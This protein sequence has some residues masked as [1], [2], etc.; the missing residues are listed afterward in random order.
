MIFS[1]CNPEYTIGLREN[2]CKKKYNST[3]YSFDEQRHVALVEDMVSLSLFDVP[4]AVIHLSLL[5][6]TNT[7]F[8][9]NDP[10]VL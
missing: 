5:I 2:K 9:Q 7:T 4:N 1:G 8:K 3:Q 10:Q 6:Y